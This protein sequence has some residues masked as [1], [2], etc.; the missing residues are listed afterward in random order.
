MKKMLLFII[1]L[2][3]FHEMSFAQNTFPSSGDAGI[4]T[5]Y[6][7]YK[8]TVL[9]TTSGVPVQGYI[10][11]SNS[12]GRANMGLYNDMGNSVSIQMSGSQY[13]SPSLYN[14]AGVGSQGSGVSSFRITTNGEKPNGGNTPIEFIAGG[15]NDTP[16][17]YITPGNP[18]NVLI[19]K[20]SQTNTSYKL[21]VNGNIRAN[22]VTVNSTGADYVFD[23][24]YQLL[25]LDSLNNYIERHHHL[26]GIPSAKEMQQNGMNVGDAYTSLLV[27][28][29]EMTRYMIAEDQ[30]IRDQSKEIKALNGK[31]KAVQNNKNR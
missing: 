9:D 27:K 8:L 20:T 18:G 19:G 16:A 30:I 2:I 15:Y 31:I 6:P 26:P 7:N 12:E 14:T 17:M 3:S 28:L 23:S 21:D 1:G 10:S 29:E 22:Q 4:G 5:I 11:N 24:T 25:S 13:V